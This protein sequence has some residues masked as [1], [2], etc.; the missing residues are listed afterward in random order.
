MR[1]VGYLR[2]STTAQVKDG[3]GL[4]VQERLIKAWAR[5]EGH[6]LV[7]ILSDNGRSGTLAETE[8]PGLLDALRAVETHEAEGIVIT[9]IDRLARSLTVQE[10]V[11]GQV[12]RLGGKVFTVD[13]GEVPQDDVD[14]PM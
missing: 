4:P 8:R 7:R 10:G 11:M 14:D 3:L 6:R 2:V 5:K 1:L 13:G 12:W 9:S